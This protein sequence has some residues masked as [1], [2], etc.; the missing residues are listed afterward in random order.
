MRDKKCRKNINQDGIKYDKEIQS[1][2]RWLARGDRFLAEEL[3]NEMHIAMLNMEPG[4]DKPLCLRVAKCRAI[5]YLRS[6]ARNYSYGGVIEH[7]SLEALSDAGF[8]ID[9]DGNVYAPKND[10]SVDIGG[11]DDSEK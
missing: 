7:I 4:Q 9:T 10:Y 3:R 6:R 1:I 11:A 8:Q 5:D 2:S